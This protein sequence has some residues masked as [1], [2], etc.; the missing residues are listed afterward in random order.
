M[1]LPVARRMTGGL[2]DLYFFMGP[3]P[4]AVIQQYHAVIGRPALPPYW[5]LGLHQTK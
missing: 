3:S 5:A 1:L 4:E 2:I